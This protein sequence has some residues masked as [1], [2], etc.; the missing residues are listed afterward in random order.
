[1]QVGLFGGTFNPIHNGHLKVIKEVQKRF[2]LDKTY[3]IPSALPPHKT[4]KNLAKAKDR[5]EMIRLALATCP[6]LMESTI[7][8]DAELKRSG[9]S[10][11][12]DTLNYFK[13]ILPENSQ[14]YLILGLDAF[15]EIDTW[16][17]YKDLFMLTSFIVITRFGTETAEKAGVLKTIEKYLRK[18]SLNYKCLFEQ[19]CCV[20]NE[21]QPVFLLDITP[22]NISS[23][24]IRKLINQGISVRA[25]VPETVAKFIKIKGLY[26]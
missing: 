13:S 4:Q 9:T 1:M 3:I 26:L 21:K 6:D 23:T 24:T 10:Y 14:L 17:T 2:L 7:I 19:S 22:V 11:T 25:Q 12:I 16:K 18:I 15:L 8:S 5:M 20:H